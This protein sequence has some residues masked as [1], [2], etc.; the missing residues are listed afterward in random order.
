MSTTLVAKL[1]TVT[2][3]P[4][5]QKNTWNDAI[6]PIVKFTKNVVLRLL[7]HGSEALPYHAQIPRPLKVASPP[8]IEYSVL[9]TQTIR[10]VFFLSTVL[11]W[12]S[13]VSSLVSPLLQVF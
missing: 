2:I 10:D 9:R 11:V 13:L 8:N 4:Q 12:T 6:I 7:P 1:S 5:P 3:C